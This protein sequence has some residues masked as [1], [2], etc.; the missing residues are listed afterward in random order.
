MNQQLRIEAARRDYRI[1]RMFFANYTA[2]SR[3]Y[4]A[5]L[6]ERR[7]MA[8]HAAL[9]RAYRNAPIPPPK[10]LVGRMSGQVY[11]LLEAV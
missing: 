2:M 6:W 9:N 5:R 7:T 11:D 4:Q 10:R 1:A 8:A 3:T